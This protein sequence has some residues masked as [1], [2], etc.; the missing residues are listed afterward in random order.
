MNADKLKALGWKRQYDSINFDAAVENTVRLY[1]DNE[2]WWRKIK[3][4]EYLEY[5]KRQYAARLPKLTRPRIDFVRANTQV[6][7][8][9][10]NSVA[11]SG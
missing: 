5:Y 9:L 3:S 6:R 4:G 8:F 10:F 11:L 1:R 2:S 7:P